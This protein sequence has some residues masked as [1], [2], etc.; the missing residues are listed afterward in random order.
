ML[1]FTA[2]IPPPPQTH[3]WSQDKP[4]AVN[5]CT[6]RHC[7]GGGGGG[8]AFG[9]LLLCLRLIKFHACIYSTIFS[10]FKKTCIKSFE[11]SFTKQGSVTR[12]YQ[13]CP[14]HFSYILG[15]R[16]LDWGGDKMVDWEKGHHGDRVWGFA[17]SYIV[18]KNP[19]ST[20]SFT[21]HKTWVNLPTS[22]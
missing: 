10:I 2:K 1:I 21:L 11:E 15:K 18:K 16:D 22:F 9:K 8:G 17:P 13:T 7:L 19:L 3:C 12:I 4:L 14:Q 5:S 20:Q 6:Y